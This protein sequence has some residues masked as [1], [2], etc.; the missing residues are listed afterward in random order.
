MIFY[1]GNLQTA[2]TAAGI[3]SKHLQRQE[4]IL[5]QQPELGKAMQEIVANG[6]PINLTTEIRFKLYCFAKVVR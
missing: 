1:F 3:Y 4:Y 2:P 5:Q 6:H